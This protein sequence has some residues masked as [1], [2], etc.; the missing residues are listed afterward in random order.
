MDY[1]LIRIDDLTPESS[2]SRTHGL[3]VMKAGVAT[4][5]TVGQLLDLVIGAAPGALDTLDELAAALADDSAFS[6]TITTLINTKL[7][8]AG[9]AM[10]GDLDIASHLLSNAI[11][12]SA[13]IADP[14]NTTKRLQWVL[15]AISSATTRSLTMPDR[16]VNLGNVPLS[17]RAKSAQQTATLG[18]LITFAHGL[19]GTP[20][21]STL[22]ASIVNTSGGTDLGYASGTEIQITTDNLGSSNGVGVAVWADATNIY[23]RVGN[24]ALA[25]GINGSTGVG[26]ITF[27]TTNWKVCLGGQL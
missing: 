5:M 10:T 18:G 21:I 2:P 7:S 9:G 17:G 1:P 19:G 13:L 14:T 16:N 27:G 23:G 25:T 15:S 22:F 12:V 4:F 6:A 24:V 11:V 20:D 26:N 3:P 8:K